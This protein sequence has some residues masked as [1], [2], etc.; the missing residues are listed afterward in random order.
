MPAAGEGAAATPRWTDLGLVPARLWTRAGSDAARR[1]GGWL[2]A[3]VLVL[4]LG[5]DN[6]G[7]APT[8]WDWTALLL[9][10]LCAIVLVARGAVRLD[11]LAAVLPA[12][13]LGLALWGFASAG[14]SASATQPLLESQR[15]LAY[16]GVVY[17]ALLVVRSGDMRALLAGSCTAATLVCCYGLLTRLFPERI[18]LFDAIAGYRLEAPLGYWNALGIYAAIAA[19]IAAG[20]A[21]RGRSAVG[22][23]LGAAATVVLVTTVYFAYSRG[24]WLALAAGVLVMLALDR[25]RLEAVTALAVL[26]V[27]PAVA[28]WQASR[29]APLTNID[30]RLSA[31]EQAGGRLA[32][33]LA[34]LAFAAAIVMLAYRLLERVVR[35]PTLVRYAY[36]ALLVVAVAGGFA[37]AVERYGSPPTI[38]RK[39]YDS[40]VGPG[41]TVSN[42][43]LN[44][45]LFSLSSTGRIAQWKVAWREYEAHP[46]LGA[47]AGS[48]ARYWNEYRTQE[49]HILNVHN[50][51]LETLAELGPIGLGLLAIA[52]VTPLAAAV[53]ARRRKLVPAAAGAYVAF[54]LHAVVDWDWQMP[55]VTVAALLCGAGLLAAAAP[56][57][58]TARPLRPAWRSALVALM[59]AGAAAAFVGLRGNQAI[60][61]S[62]NAASAGKWSK[63]AAEARTA[64]SWA[65]WSSE[66][67]QLLGEAQAASGQ[68][69]ASLVSFRRALAKDH[70]SWEI[71]LD[72]AVAS[73]GSERR[74]AFAEATKLNPL[75]P[76]I[77]SWKAYLSGKAG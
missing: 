38:A 2:F 64:R 51:Y 42:G 44:D 49:G 6:G 48:Y 30:A 24:A 74:H 11:P 29:S 10:A 1:A 22:R 70:Q 23:A 32:I 18:G 65:P 27:F 52:L 69:A 40:F 17:G 14:W 67:W 34:A 54:L 39:L 35:V 59:A 77:A 57:R 71:W 5:A 76:E 46:W 45:R 41:H 28:V 50:L 4:W 19:L 66:P 62:Q 37:A 53:I 12:A 55:A 56:E 20:F 47:G 72:L 8:S 9:F 60:A 63:A 21:I 58:A 31:A 61:A 7:Y 36:S 15:T 73:S 25:Q 75:S 13:L 3:F 43:N 33:V 16:V 26:A 68:R